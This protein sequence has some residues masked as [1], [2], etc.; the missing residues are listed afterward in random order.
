MDAYTFN[1]YLLFIFIIKSITKYLTPR[2]LVVVPNPQIRC[3]SIYFYIL[4]EINVSILSKACRNNIIDS[5][6]LYFMRVAK[7]ST[8]N[9]YTENS[10]IIL[11]KKVW[12]QM[13]MNEKMLNKILIKNIS[14]EIKNDRK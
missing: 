4:S 11:I 1:F 13:K 7:L 5:V 12:I 9:T 6:Y 10:E 2:R 14:V 3:Q 8:C